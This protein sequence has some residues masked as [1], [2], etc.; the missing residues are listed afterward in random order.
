[1]RALA[2]TVALLAS[3]GAHG[4]AH[5]DPVR[6]VD[7]AGTWAFTPQGA[8]KTTIEVPGGGWYK[9][10]FDTPRAVY[11]REIEVPDVLRDQVVTL[12]LGAVNHE[13]TVYVD[14]EKVGTDLTSFTPQSFDLTRFV[15]PGGTHRLRIDVKGKLAFTTLP[16]IGRTI[17]GYYGGP[18]FSIPVGVEWSEGIAQGIYA[19]AELHAH[20]PVRVDDVFVRTSVAREELV[21][22]VTLANGSSR[23]RTV[24][25]GGDVPSVD[26]QAPERVVTVPAGKRRTVTVGPLRWPG[27][28][29]TYW[30]PN[31][32]YREG[33]RAALHELRLSLDGEG[34][35]DE[36]FGFREVRQVGSTYELN[37]VRFNVRGDS[38]SGANYDRIDHGGVGD[39]FH[40]HPGFLPPSKGNGGWPKAIDNYQRLNWNVIRM[41]QVPGSEYM[42]DVADERGM[43]IISETGIRG[44]QS[45]QD[46]KAC[47]ECFVE[48]TRDLVRRDRRHPSV[49]RWSVSNE[50]DANRGGDSLA[51]QRSLVEA[52]RA[53]DPTLPISIDVSGETYEGLGSDGFAVFQH[54]VD[55]DGKIAPG[56]TDDVHPRK[57]RP[58]GRGEFIWPAGAL[59]Q[60]FTWMATATQ[61]MREKD[62]SDIR[63]Y[64]MSS[65][66]ASVI[67][68]VKRTDYIT[69]EYTLPLYGEDNLPDPW[70]N[71]QIQ[72]MQKAFH[73][74]AV[75]DR[76]FWERQK[77]SDPLGRWPVVPVTVKAGAAVE[78]ELMVFND[79]F[80]GER[81]DVSWQVHAGDMLVAEGEQPVDVP[82]GG[83][84]TLP[85]RFTAPA[86][87]GELR[88]SLRTAKPGEGELFRDD[89][90]RLLVTP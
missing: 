77:L 31:A 11:E 36:R 12:E 51:F 54:Y 76:D 68:G 83:R 48:H 30:W 90:Q 7:L 79:T 1:M 50:P 4:T 80:A 13:A 33:Y 71:P 56:Y 29:D 40:T 21:Y 66:W 43:L 27:G 45:R 47:P 26:L 64:T 25:L 58:F 23:E 38:I 63:P 53:L 18:P 2:A 61:K 81:V 57:D 84:A 89:A 19:S 3:A 42:L 73:P 59:P 72:R 62:A 10:G 39:A 52:A 78:R 34:A 55:E 67:P 15:R 32:P 82:L 5:A 69:E 44:S 65:A 60:A 85:L 87:P 8:A 37:G 75:V 46:F 86:T 88:V 22:D 74:V 28:R 24:R 17:P 6:V 9:Q 20:G 49:V 16:W 41:H 14:D 35:H 70:S